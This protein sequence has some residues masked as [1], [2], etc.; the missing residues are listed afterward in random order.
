M[1][2]T[3]ETQDTLCALR[4]NQVQLYQLYEA[5]NKAAGMIFETINN[6]L[7]SSSNDPSQQSETVEYQRRS[8]SF[9]VQSNR[10]IFESIWSKVSSRAASEAGHNEEAPQPNRK[11][12]FVGAK[13]KRSLTTEQ[14]IEFWKEKV[15]QLQQ[16]N[17]SLS[18]QV[19]GLRTSLENAETLF[20][21][22]RSTHHCLQKVSLLTSL[23]ILLSLV[24]P[25]TRE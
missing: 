22:H 20:E 16:E 2:A 8:L 13:Q 23:L 24:L 10:P 5:H 9:I 12:H 17:E 19:Q 25:R 21:S 4:E 3:R 1:S 7:M 15:A 18:S 11:V 6:C 14:E